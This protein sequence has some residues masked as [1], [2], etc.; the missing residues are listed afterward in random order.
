MFVSEKLPEIENYMI[1]EV[2]KAVTVESMAS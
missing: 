2:F 1:F